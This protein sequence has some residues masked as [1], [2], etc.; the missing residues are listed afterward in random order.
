MNQREFTDRDIHLGLDGELP[1]DERAGFEAWLESNPDRKAQ[2]VRLA[3]DRDRLRLALGAIADEPVPQQLQNLVTAPVHV[4]R[5]RWRRLVWHAVAAVVLL[6]A[7]L[8]AGYFAGQSGFGADPGVQLADNAIQAHV[9]YAAEKRHAVEV[10][11]DDSEHLQSWLSNRTGVSL[12]LPDLSS[13][14]FHL[15]GGRLLP[16]TRG[17]AALLLYEDAGGARVSIYVTASSAPKSWGKVESQGDGTTAIYWLDQGFGCAVVGMLPDE[18]M[19]AVARDAWRQLLAG[20]R[21]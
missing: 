19:S 17:P 21:M 5:P 3:A 13:E 1:D 10:A 7:G 8:G 20:M 18:R 12:T 11:S 14:G 16:T 2:S 6:A 9:V 4:R 15:L